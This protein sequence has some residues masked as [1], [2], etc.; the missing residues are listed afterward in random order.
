[1]KAI[2]TIIFLGVF[3]FSWG[4]IIEAKAKALNQYLLV[5]ES[6]PVLLG[7]FPSENTYIFNLNEK[8][9]FENP[10]NDSVPIRIIQSE[11]LAN[12]NYEVLIENREGQKDIQLLI[13]FTE[14]KLIL[15]IETDKQDRLKIEYLLENLTIK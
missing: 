15:L 4:Q 6:E 2:I 9:A 7:A 3:Q 10:D 1:M 14:K 13:D 12:G 11:K 8:I 5:P